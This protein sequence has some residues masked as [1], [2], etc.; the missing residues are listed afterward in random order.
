V[1]GTGLSCF[2]RNEKAGRRFCCGGGELLG[3]GED[4]G[5]DRGASSENTPGKFFGLDVGG[6]EDSVGAF[7]TSEGGSTVC[8]AVCSVS[9]AS[10]ARSTRLRLVGGSSS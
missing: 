9:A 1:V 2:L 10:G 8:A 4:G 5:L 3:T 7:E 6:S